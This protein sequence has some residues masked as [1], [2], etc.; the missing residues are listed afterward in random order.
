MSVGKANS[1]EHSSAQ[2]TFFGFGEGA[3]SAC[4]EEF[5]DSWAIDGSLGE[6]AV[7]GS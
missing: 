7:S 4:L 5:P 6:L 1:S 2:V 3:V